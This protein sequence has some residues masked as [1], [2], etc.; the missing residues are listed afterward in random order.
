MPESP[1]STAHPYMANSVAAIRQAMLDA[2]GAGD[3]EE[4]FVRIPKAHRMK[5]ELAL[6]PGMRSEAELRRHLLGLLAGKQTC[7]AHL[8]F[9]GT[10]CWQHHV[11]A[12]CEEVVRRRELL[13]PVFG[14][15]APDY[16]RNQAWFEFASQLGEL[17]DC[18][19]VGLPV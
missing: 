2:I 15:P 3:I 5:G 16:G 19:L 7:E 1:V 8:G 12:A 18:D 9:L 13:T 14:S 6:P 4:L 17:V 10:G 11:P